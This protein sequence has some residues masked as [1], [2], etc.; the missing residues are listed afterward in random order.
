MPRITVWKDVYLFDCYELASQGATEAQMARIL[1]IALITFRGWER[2]KPLFALALERGRKAYKRKTKN[3]KEKSLIANYVYNRLPKEMQRTWNKL[4]AAIKAQAPQRV[5]EKILEGKSK[6]FKQYLWIYAFVN[7]NFSVS[8]ACG[9][10]GIPM[11]TFEKWKER[12]PEFAKLFV[13]IIEA[14]KDFVEDALIQ[15][16]REKREAPTIFASKGLLRDRGYDDRQNVNVNVSGQVE[17]VH[18]ILPFQKIQP[19]LTTEMQQNLLDAIRK[20]KA[21]EARVLEGGPKLLP[22]ET[23]DAEWEPHEG[24]PI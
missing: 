7:N 15:L 4:E 2:K 22:C 16:V 12:E 20:A 9:T 14:K 24:M 19:F 18:N 11:A 13:Q 1:G 8:K 10:I 17:H 5:M 21:V 3:G 6:Y 23:V